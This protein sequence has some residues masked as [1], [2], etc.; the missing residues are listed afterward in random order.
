MKRLF[1]KTKQV[2]VYKAYELEIIGNKKLS[3]FD[4]ILNI[5]LDI[6]SDTRYFGLFF[7]LFGQFLTLHID[8]SR[9]RDHA[10]ISIELS[11]LWI[12][13]YFVFYDTRHWDDENNK[14]EEYE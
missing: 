12:S 6:L 5:D 3:F 10:G 11:I 9:R 8:F 4:Q 13:L 2:D 7:T 14:W 1:S